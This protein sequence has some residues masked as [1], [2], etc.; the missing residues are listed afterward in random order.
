MNVF[1]DQL[2]YKFNISE[3]NQ[4]IGVFILRYINYTEFNPLTRYYYCPNIDNIIWE[5]DL[6]KLIY[7]RDLKRA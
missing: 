6:D 7:T 3:S 4:C 2:S 5:D 1:Q